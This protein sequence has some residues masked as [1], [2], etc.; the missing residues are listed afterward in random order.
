M[1]RQLL[2]LNT[3]FLLVMAA[4][5]APVSRQQAFRKAQDFMQDMGVNRELS[6]VMDTS[7]KM[8]AN[9]E[10]ELLYVFNAAD[11]GGFIIISG[12]DQTVSVL[13]YATEGSFDYDRLPCNAREVIDGYAEQIRLIQEKEGMKSQPFMANH[14]TINPLLTCQWN[15]AE[16]FNNDCPDFFNYGKSVTG[17]V[18]TAFAQILYYHRNSSPINSTQA[19]IT[20]Y[21]CLTN[22]VELGKIHVDAVPVGSPIDWGNMID[23]Y[24][25][26]GGTEVQKQAV[27]SLMRYCGAS[28]RMDYS[29]KVNGG[30]SANEISVVSAAK[31]YFG[32]RDD[33]DIRYHHNMTD[34]EWDAV[35]Y[36]EL[37]AGRP[38]LMSGYNN[39]GG[40]AFVCDGFKNSQY[41]IN[42]GWGGYL[43][44]YFVLSNLE[45]EGGGIGSSEGG[46]NDGQAMLVNM[47][48]GDGTSYETTMMT[49]RELSLTGKCQEARIYN[50]NA[51]VL[52]FSFSYANGTSDPN[53]FNLG[54]AAYKDDVMQGMVFQVSCGELNMT[55]WISYNGSCAVGNGWQD[56]IYEIWPVSR[57][58]NTSEWKKNGGADDLHYVATV[59]ADEIVFT[60]GYNNTPPDP[61]PG[62][63]PEPIIVTIDN[64][65]RIYGDENPSFTYSVSGGILDGQPAINCAATPTSPVGTYDI[66]ASMGTITNENVTFVNGQLTVNQAPLT[67]SA[68][69]YVRKQGEP[70]PE[71]QAEYEGFKNA[72][73]NSVLTRQP[74]F[75]CVATTESYPGTYPVYVSGAEAKNYAIT[76]VE[77]TLTVEAVEGDITG[78]GY[79][80]MVDVVCLINYIVGIGIGG[81]NYDAADLNND[82]EIDVFDVT[83]MID[84]AFQFDVVL[85]EGQNIWEDNQL[86]ISN[87]K[88][89][90]GETKVVNV[91]LTNDADF[92]AFQYDLYLPDGI[93]LLDYELDG[94]RVPESTDLTVAE[95]SD[96][97]YRFLAAAFEQET[98]SENTGAILKLTVHADN[99]MT[100]G[101]T[102]G[103][104]RQVKLSMVDGTG[105]TYS[106]MSFPVTVVE[107]SVVTANSYTRK[108]GEANPV[109]EYAVSGGA[110]EGTPEITCP[111]TETSPVGTYDI[112]VSQGTVSNYNVTF[113]KGTLT[114]E[115][116]PLT[117]SVD[118]YTKRQY[119]PMPEFTLIYE[120]FKNNEDETVLTTQPKVTCDATDDSAP[121]EYPISVIGAEAQNYDISYVNGTLTVT[122][123][124][125]YT[126]TYMVDNEVYKTFSLKQNEVIVPEPEPTKEGYTF[127]GWSEIPA[128]M[129]AH[130]VTIIGTFT[131]NPY[132]LTYLVDG[133]EY[134]TYELEFGV[135][136][137]P[138]AEPTKEGHTF[139]GWSEIP[140]TMPAHDVTVTG[141]FSIN[142]YKLTYMIDHE[143]YKEV[144]YDYGATITPEPQPEGNY[145]RFEWVDL[146]E[147]MPAND[148]TVY[149]SYEMEPDGINS[150][151]ADGK[152]EVWY[153]MDGCRLMKRPTAKGMYICNGRKV[154]VK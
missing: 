131:I 110:L 93:E 68:G 16:P 48:P 123:P 137:I 58:K 13:G 154:L 109:F 117:I 138:E 86:Q 101:N 97:S 77:G 70:N 147:T 31:K 107:P 59:T 96:G 71:F 121:G 25:N 39:I 4:I 38:V 56:G 115:A 79:V 10:G 45:P 67:I 95:Q 42:W 7:R 34:D 72:E 151:G 106:E 69:N 74:V 114:I 64:T 49:T 63:E 84:K 83:M 80:D 98:I 134:Q 14:A 146:P 65:S 12:D 19:E 40:H 11:E 15:Q 135:T 132:K 30:S 112:I 136:I 94:A 3:F 90:P 33:A 127:S 9:G 89:A 20:A 24:N 22:W 140:A 152:N 82:G 61:G 78:D 81:F 60:V 32:F 105:P 103:S 76:Y 113:V 145:V 153:T 116:A 129:P 144:M 21:D 149:A 62:P 125:S 87:F 37:A 104:F 148:V 102:T 53:A 27:A 50:G 51:A 26:G 99:S 5:A 126:L 139:S 92:V 28:V 150:V 128:T 54:L 124:A 8:K 57:I 143:I 141:T 122:E 66:V 100:A 85:P 118:N 36:A 17:C 2:L 1:K 44:G 35:I 108:Y 88:I 119:E 46:Y 18:A 73:T 75:S 41:H 142:T 29:T 52:G 6:P 47:E 120:G 55:Q 111:A 43:D 91:N 23:N 130:D 133:A